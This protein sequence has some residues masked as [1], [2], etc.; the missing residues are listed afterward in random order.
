MITKEAVENREAIR[1]IK[2]LYDQGKISREDAMVISD[3]VIKRINE[4]QTEIAKKW[5]KK[6]HPKTNFTNIMRNSY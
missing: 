5:G 4:R 2:L 6:N 3:P 1:R